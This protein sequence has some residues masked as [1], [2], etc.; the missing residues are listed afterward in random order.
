MY[1]IYIIYIYRCPYFCL[2]AKLAP[3]PAQEAVE[4]MM[5]S[6]AMEPAGV[7]QGTLELVS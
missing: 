4:S 2:P 7:W 3:D 5:E 1:Y 6:E